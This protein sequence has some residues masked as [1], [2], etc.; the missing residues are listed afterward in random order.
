MGPI[1]LHSYSLREEPVDHVFECAADLGFDGVELH[2]S[3]FDPAHVEAGVD[4]AATLASQFGVP[5]ACVDYSGDFLNEDETLR[6]KSI[7]TV[8]RTIDAAAEHAIPMVNGF[9]GWLVADLNNWSA[10]GSA[11]ATSEHYNHAAEAFNRLATHAAALKVR[12]CVEVH[13]N[14][15]HDS[16]AATQRLLERTAHE[17]LFATIDP[18]NTFAVDHAEKNPEALARIEDRIGYAHF[19]NCNHR[20]SYDYNVNLADGE[21]DITSWV[22]ALEGFGYDG[23][24]CIE[25]CGDRVPNLKKDIRYLR[26][27]RS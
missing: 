26:E 9:A 18:G 7:D 22:A 25:Y 6:E 20:D 15:I 14:T 23:P 19:K 8:K 21:I 16:I 1:N 3:H 12:V 13:M 17:N 4:H 10:N 24:Y 27:R 2:S 11:I 5:I